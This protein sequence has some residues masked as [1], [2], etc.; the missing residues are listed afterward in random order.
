MAI[1]TKILLL[2]GVGGVLATGFY[3]SYTGVGLQ[4]LS[5]KQIISKGDPLAAKRSVRGGGYRFG[6]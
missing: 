6:K 3:A 4:K 5:Q 2:C 1:F